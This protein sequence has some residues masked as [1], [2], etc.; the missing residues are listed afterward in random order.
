MPA[1]KKN[2]AYSFSTA[3]VD[4]ANRPSFKVSPT[5][6]TGDFTLIG[7]G[8]APVNLTTLPIQD[9]PGTIAV[10]ISLTQA[11][12]NF[13]RVMIVA[14][15]VAG[16]EWD[17]VYFYIV[18]DL[19]RSA[20]PVNML[21]VDAAG[22]AK[23]QSGVSTN[24]ALPNFEF[25]MTDSAAHAPAAGKTV[26]ATRSIDKGAFAACTNNP[27]EIASGMYGIDFAAGDLN[28]GVIDVRFT[29]PG[30]DDLNVTFVTTP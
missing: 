29:A 16:A 2:V 15:D 19:V 11:E 30:C 17:D 25:L 3:L 9:P 5:L 14:R 20:N 26:A 12:M 7:N 1:P 8:G 10:K 18:D 4:Q 28:G 6:A 22:R 23:I 13:D 24:A 21:N 27:S